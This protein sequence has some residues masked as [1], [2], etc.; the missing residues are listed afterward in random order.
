MHDGAARWVTARRGSM[1]N[2]WTELKSSDLVAVDL[3]DWLGQ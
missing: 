3:L 2:E 1:T